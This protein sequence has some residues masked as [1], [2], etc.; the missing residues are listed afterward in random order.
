MA[1]GGFTLRDLDGGLG[2][3]GRQGPSQYA[4]IG[5]S[6]EAEAIAD[7]NPVLVTGVGDVAT[8]FGVGELA[9]MLRR[10]LRIAGSTVLAMPLQRAAGGTVSAAQAA[11][12]GG[13]MITTAMV[14][15]ALGRQHVRMEY[16]V[17]G[18]AGTAEIRLIVDGVPLPAFMP[19]SGDYG[20]VLVI[21]VESLGS[22]ATGVILADRFSPTITAPT[23]AV[24][25]D[26][27]E[28]DFTYA[29]ALAAEVAP[30]VAKLADHPTQFENIAL[31]GASQP[32]TWGFLRTAARALPTSHGEY[33]GV[34]VQA[35]GPDLASGGP[36]TALTTAAWISAAAAAVDTP[37]R[38]DSPRLYVWLPHAERGDI[39][40]PSMYPALG[41][42]A[43]RQPWE[44][45]NE[46]GEG[47]YGILPEV[48]EI[49]PRMTG[50]QIDSMDDVF[51][52][53]LQHHVG[54]QGIYI[55]EARLWG[56]Y[57]QLGV[58]GTDYTGTERRRTIDAACRVVRAGLVSRINANFP[59]RNGRIAPA[60]VA[61]LEANG[62][63]LLRGLESVGA[64]TEPIVAFSDAAAGILVTEELL[65]EVSIQPPGKA[66]RISGTIAFSRGA[67]AQETA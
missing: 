53:T 27:V 19:A 46:V 10:A 58:P 51:Y 11:Q 47:D 16:T 43:R 1:R 52:C 57:P 65:F 34:H 61:D 28:F 66:R 50:A 45:V 26:G 12:I 23:A 6:S 40:E 55:T 49:Y 36:A 38:L 15:H 60:A 30:A 29:T 21:P 31:A 7:Q 14:G 37:T 41:L 2:V 42:M 20:S 8:L 24:A 22:L 25:G 17:A 18:V 39:I 35:A 62:V 56:V 4:A 32:A 67:A 44:S 59:T 33:C 64:F 5:V 9:T 54:K 63:R 48:D 3:T 13:T